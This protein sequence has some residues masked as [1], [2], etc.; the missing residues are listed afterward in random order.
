LKA[1]LA[2]DAKAARRILDL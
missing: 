2:E 1:Q